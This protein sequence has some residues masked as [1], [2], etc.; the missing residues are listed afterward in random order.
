MTLSIEPCGDTLRVN[1]RCLTS[2]V[3]RE[4]E[5]AVQAAR[6]PA[7]AP[8]AW[9]YGAAR[10]DLVRL[11]LRRP[12]LRELHVCVMNRELHER[13]RPLPRDRR[14]R[15]HMPGEALVPMAPFAVSPGELHLADPA[16]HPLRDRL[17]AVLNA[18]FN[19]ARHAAERAR[20]DRQ[21][22]DNAQLLAVDPR[23]VELRDAR[24]AIVIAGGPT[25]AAHYDWIRARAE[26]HNVVAVARAVLPLLAA[27]I[28]PAVVVLSDR[29]LENAAFFPSDDRLRAC[30]LVYIASAA[31]SVLALWNGRRASFAESD[32]F[33]GGSV[34]HCAADLATRMGAQAVHL[35]G[36]D[37]SFPAGASHIEGAALDRYVTDRV[38]MQTVNGF[39]EL[40]PTQESMAQYHRWL[41]SLIAARPGI[42][43]IKHDRRGVPL[44]GAQWADEVRDAA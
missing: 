34:A 27:D 40:V 39:G 20:Y 1:G 17:L 5:A 26:S 3:D 38:A 8:V 44:R 13:T 43:W 10:G 28:V 2:A 21:E 16:A 9:V 23:A 42:R 33:A 14:L 32:F 15:V 30:R 37:F 29:D 18:P 25:T 19:E 31:P 22:A 6:I 35:F 11:L 41:E 24:D 4:A 7:E 12:A 36:F